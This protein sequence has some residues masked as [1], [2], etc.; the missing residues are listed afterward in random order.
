M[1]TSV[2]RTFLIATILATATGAAGLAPTLARAQTL[3]EIVARHVAARGGVERWQGLRSLR[4]TGRAVAGPGREVLVSR[5]VV[6]PGRIRTEFTSQGVTDVYVFDGERGWYVSPSTGVFD[7]QPMSPENLRQA[8]EQAD[9]EGPL[10]SWRS[11]GHQVELI[12]KETVD[13]REAYRLRTTLAGGTTRD[14]LIDAQSFLTIRTDTTRRVRGQT[15]Q[16]ETTFGDYRESGGL[17]FP[18]SIVS[19]AK[20][21]PQSLRIVVD[22]VEVNPG[23]DEQRF[24][25]SA[26]PP[27]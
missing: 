17:W 9:I 6:R 19:T 1:D 13:G 11:K 24:K 18:R 15:L 27:Q 2:R 26:L 14:D 23:I 12:G 21:R 10:V 4:M 5:E 16:L 3:D 25:P 8:A 7:Q 22:T 20:G